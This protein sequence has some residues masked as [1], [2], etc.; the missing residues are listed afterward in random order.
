MRL[1]RSLCLFQ[2]Q[3]GVSQQWVPCTSDTHTQKL[4]CN[5]LVL[6]FNYKSN[7]NYIHPCIQWYW[8]GLE[9]SVWVSSIQK[10]AEFPAW[11][12]AK[13]GAQLPGQFFGSVDKSCFLLQSTAIQLKRQFKVRLRIRAVQIIEIELDCSQIFKQSYFNIVFK[14]M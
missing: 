8:V 14:W 13:R 3:C 7:R 10:R 9:E 6:Q 4:T 5:S 11:R 12:S 2:G 1:E